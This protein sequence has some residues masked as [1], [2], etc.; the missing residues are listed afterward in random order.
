MQ[1]VQ[2]NQE[3]IDSFAKVSEKIKSNPRFAHITVN[4]EGFP[5]S[6]T[7]NRV[8]FYLAKTYKS[9]CN[10]FSSKTNE[11][12]DAKLYGAVKNMKSKAIE[13]LLGNDLTSEDRKVLI[14]SL[15]TLNT[16]TA[17]IKYLNT[18]SVHMPSSDEKF[19]SLHA[20]IEEHYNKVKEHMKA[21]TI[22]L[23]KFD[24][25]GKAPV[26]I[27]LA[28]LMKNEIQEISKKPM[29]T[30][31]ED[32]EKDELKLLDHIERTY[33][34]DVV[35]GLSKGREHD[36][37]LGNLYNDLATGR[38]IKL[39]IGRLRLEQELHAKEFP[40]TSA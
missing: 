19:I 32:F 22:E 13:L 29:Y 30:S 34:S 23:E 37:L 2:N 17:K 1:P 31:V 14:A 8:S 39:D 12:N 24:P 5:I 36:E 38:A 16:K 40:K 11:N 25:E 9:M 35:P 18:K 27:N 3:F 7:T 21:M 28:T 26:F 10:Y 33:R 6:L 4:K 20:K 15:E